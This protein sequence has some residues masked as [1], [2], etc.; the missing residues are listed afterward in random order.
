M[1]LEEIIISTRRIA[2]RAALTALAALC[3]TGCKK[4][5]EGVL[6]KEE[7]A[8]LM[9]DIHLGEALIDFNYSAY[10]ND[11]TRKV[12]KQSIYAAHHVSAEEVDTSFV[13]YGNHIEDYIKVYDRTIEIIQERQR[14]T[15]NAAHAQI[16]VAGDS[17]QVWSGPQR[18]VVNSRMPSRVVT[19]NLLPD[20]TWK[21]GDIYIL[22]YKL[23]NSQ[24]NVTGRLLVDY[25][26]GTTGYS[27]ETTV[28][29]NTTS[30]HIQPDTT[31]TPLRIYG[32]MAFAPENNVAFEIDSISLTRVRR[33]L[34][35][36]KRFR[37]SVFDYGKTQA[38]NE[39]ISDVFT[40]SYTQYDTPHRGTPSN[41]HRQRQEVDK[42]A[43]P[44]TS[45]QLGRSS[46]HRED[47]EE[48]KPTPAQRRDAARQRNAT[49]RP[50][51]GMTP[52][53]NDNTGKMRLRPA[54]QPH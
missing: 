18:L 49:T 28:Q 51:K 33:E 38:A 10:P 42:A 4:T 41:A 11:S 36:G 15:A 27:D 22:N 53:K 40:S 2:V 20:S 29:R 43:L 23:I 1:Q 37:Q 3:L 25:D 17:V 31:L 13:W 32:Y 6:D 8:Q 21:K 14:N 26:N 39:A 54:E 30:L 45:S 52:R 12:L 46:E 16:S 34:M 35:P 44:K 5:P 9:A 7:M 24:A 19:F 48:H 47:A 50:N